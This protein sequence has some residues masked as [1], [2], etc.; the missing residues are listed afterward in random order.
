MGV[1]Y[2]FI[3]VLISIPLMISIT[4]Y[5]LADHWYIFFGKMCMFRFFAIKSGFLLLLSSR[6]SLCVPDV[7]PLSDILFANFSLPFHGLTFYSINCV[8]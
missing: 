6:C 1:R 7:D 5:I 2:Y 3:V 4:E 8:I